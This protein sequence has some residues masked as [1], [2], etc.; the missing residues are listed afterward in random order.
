MVFQRPAYP[1]LTAKQFLEFSFSDRKA[2]LDEG[3][4][5]VL[6]GVTKWHATI[7]SNLLSFVHGQLRGTP[8]R[9]YLSSFPLRVDSHSVR[10]ADLFVTHGKD[11]PEHEDDLACDDPLVIFEIIHGS[12]PR[13][14]LTVKVEEYRQLGS[15]DTLVIIDADE[16]R[17]RVLQRAGRR[18]WSDNG[19]DVPID[20][21]LP[22][23]GIVVPHAEIFSRD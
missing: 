21:R 4:V 13:T 22:S 5:R 7:Q 16:E 17:L 1:L 10:R 23:L 9:T 19:F 20:V 8:Y 12:R 18:N 6:D 15:L 11:G 14:N 3:V 2:E